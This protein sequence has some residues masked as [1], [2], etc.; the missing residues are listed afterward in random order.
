MA[1]SKKHQFKYIQ[2]FG[3]SI[4]IVENSQELRNTNLLGVYDKE[5]KVIHMA[6]SISKDKETL[7]HEIFH[8]VFH[9]TGLNQSISHELE[10]VIVENMSVALCENFNL[11]LK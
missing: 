4:P 7:I 8:A 10:E 11:R 5:N 9:R 2:V 1:K 3:L 6:N